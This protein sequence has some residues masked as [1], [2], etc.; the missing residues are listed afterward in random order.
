MA[1][2]IATRDLLVRQRPKTISSARISFWPSKAFRRT[3]GPASCR[4]SSLRLWTAT[5]DALC[6]AVRDL[7]RLHLDQIAGLSG[8][9]ADLDAICARK[10]G[11]NDTAPE[12]NG[13]IPGVG[14]IHRAAIHPLLRTEETFSKETRL[15]PP[16]RR[17]HGRDITIRAG[18]KERLGPNIKKDGSARYPTVC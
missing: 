11:T 15:L 10:Q 17:T 13:T 1:W 5:N 7:A 16:G 8:K 18:G 6:C 2:S 14:P 4:P 12:V 9:I 3:A